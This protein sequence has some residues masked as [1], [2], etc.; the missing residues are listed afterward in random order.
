MTW[1]SRWDEIFKTQPWG[2]YPGEELIRFVARNFYGVPD[3]AR[4]QLLEVGCGPGANLW[5]CSREGFT[6]YGIDGSQH[7]VRLARQRLDSECPGWQGRIEAGDF[8]EIPYGD[9]FFDAVIDN[10]SICHN[11]FESSCLIYREIARVLKPSGKLFIRTFAS[12]SFGDGTGESLGRR[13]WRVSE[14]PM[15]GKGLSRFTDE[16]DFG[17]LF[18]SLLSI[19]SCEMLIR[20]AGDRAHDIREWIMV[21]QKGLET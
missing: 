14:G 13:T 1:D 11:D 6:V 12:G 17:E 20:T 15:L 5:F 3:R 9:D 7:A 10:E 16:A 4:V 21:L 2:K 18:P 19:R 8:S